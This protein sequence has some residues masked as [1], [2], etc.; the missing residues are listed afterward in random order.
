MK[1]KMQLVHYL[2]LS[3]LVEP[4]NKTFSII[5][6]NLSM[7][8]PKLVRLFHVSIKPTPRSCLSLP[9]PTPPLKGSVATDTVYNR[10]P[11]AT[12]HENNHR[13]HRSPSEHTPG[14]AISLLRVPIVPPC[15][16]LL[17]SP[18][19]YRRHA[20]LGLCH[21]SMLT[22]CCSILSLNAKKKLSTRTPVTHL[23]LQITYPEASPHQ[24]FMRFHRCM[25]TTSYHRRV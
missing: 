6:T 4:K 19:Q 13:T 12:S 7:C 20:S 10:C 16:L 3:G 14:T 21:H 17:S 15:T 24:F 9:P 5:G 8:F 22:A 23:I 2:L 18:S 11:N 25:A 1:S